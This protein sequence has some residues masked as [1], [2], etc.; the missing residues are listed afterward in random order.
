M[1]KGVDGSI[2]LGFVVPNQHRIGRLL[3]WTREESLL[4]QSLPS[5]LLARGE[6]DEEGSSKASFVTKPW[7]GLAGRSGR[8][9]ATV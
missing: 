6:E 3:K 9:L 2:P 7:K 5:G 1:S 4:S 8:I